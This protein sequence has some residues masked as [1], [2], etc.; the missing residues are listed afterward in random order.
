MNGDKVQEEQGLVSKSQEE[1]SGKEWITTFADLSLILL[2][3]F[4]LLYSISTLNE[5]RFQE[6]FVSVRR[7]LGS[8]EGKIP[9]KSTRP[10][11]FMDEVRAMRQLRENQQNVFSDLTSYQTDKG[12]EGIVGAKLQEGEITLSVPSSVLFSSGS[13]ELK[14]EGQ[15]I[16]QQLVDFFVRYPD[17]TI[18]IQGHTDNVPPGKN[19][20]FKDNWEIS[21]LRAINVLRTIIDAGIEPKRLTAT[22]FADLEP[23][24]PNSTAQN[25]AR[26]RRVEFVLKKRIGEKY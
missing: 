26:N 25:R 17:Q 15:R 2:V 5:E 21:S 16:V 11:V 4:V 1:D 7:A 24:V 14:P 18:N 6:S 9:I 19:S 3:F 13:V 22:G 23:V 12:L 10:G 8:K 20:R